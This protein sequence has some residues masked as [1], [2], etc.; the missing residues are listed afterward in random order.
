[1]LCI[2]QRVITCMRAVFRDGRERSSDNGAVLA[3]LERG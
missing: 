2:C 3:D 1:M